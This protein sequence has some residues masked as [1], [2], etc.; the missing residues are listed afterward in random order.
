MQ[1][2]TLFISALFLS[3]ATQGQAAELLIV[4]PIGDFEPRIETL[5]EKVPD[6]EGLEGYLG[7]SL[8]YAG[9]GGI[10]DVEVREYEDERWLAHEVEGQLRHTAIGDKLGMLSETATI[11]KFDSGEAMCLESLNINCW[12]VRNKVSVRISGKALE[13]VI[14]AYLAQFPPTYAA[15]SPDST[16]AAGE[17][18]R[19]LES[20]DHRLDLL[21]QGGAEGDLM[22]WIHQ[23]LNAFLLYRERYYGFEATPERGQLGEALRAKDE[24][25]LREKLESYKDWWSSSD[26][27]I[28]AL[29]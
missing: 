19:L 25:L 27:R 29:K 4:G 8:S 6:R 20:A 3:L 7:Y 14:N 26:K 2:S 24:V 23:E 15:F 12:W 22:A 18:E 16:W 13:T 1:L 28:N 10:V 9:P 5:R 21:T 17:M 11:R